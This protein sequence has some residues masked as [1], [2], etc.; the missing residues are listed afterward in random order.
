M[1]GEP[2]RAAL[3]AVAAAA[4]AVGAVAVVM[5]PLEETMP[6]YLD[7][8]AALREGPVAESFEPLGYP[9]LISVVPT[10]SPA[11][12]ISLLHLVCFS[13]LVMMVLAE[14]LHHLR[15]AVGWARPVIVV[16]AAAA[17]LNPYVLANLTR[18]NDNAVNTALVLLLYLVAR[19]RAQPGREAVTA[20]GGGALSGALIFIRPNLLSLL[21]IL[22]IRPLERGRVTASVAAGAVGLM[23][24]YA[25]ASMVATGRPLFWPLNGPYNLL[26]GN[27]P[28]AMAS[29]VRD[30]NA[31]SSLA[32]AMSWCGHA[33]AARQS[34]SS[35]LLSCARRFVVE[36]PGPAMAV[37]AYKVFNLILRPN[38]RLADSRGKQALQWAMVILPVAWWGITLVS[39]WSAGRTVDSFTLN[40]VL[41]FALPFVVTNSDPRFRLP[42]DAIYATSLMQM[43]AR[44]EPARDG[45]PSA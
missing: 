36:N 17:L 33:D 9:W 39:W 23:L 18:V 28:S 6:V 12:A 31:E 44:R 30:Y 2:W 41:L 26:A 25:G 5:R 35:V 21:P 8:A 40:F 22:A 4:L 15:G 27:N 45:R 7:L 13:G 1:R 43:A 3:L 16:L 19:H 38:L 34:S 14:G 42:L 11:S 20:L 32:H 37:T 29:L 10:T 24:A